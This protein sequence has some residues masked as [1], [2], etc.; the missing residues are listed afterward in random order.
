MFLSDKTIKEYIQSGKI[1]VIGDVEI[2]STGVSLHLGNELL[3]PRPYQVVDSKNPQEIEYLKYNLTQA[4]YVL[5]PNDFVLGCTKEI[6]K[7]DRDILTMIDG[8][9]TYARIGMSIHLSAM[10][11]DGLPFSEES[12]VLEI[13]NYGFF[14]ILLHPGEKLGTYLFSMLSAPI[15]GKKNSLYQNQNGVTPPRFV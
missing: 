5:K 12:S 11:L 6:V 10:F 1:K 7:T 8:R 2:E 13:K 3:L 4:P 9:S 14:N 15:E